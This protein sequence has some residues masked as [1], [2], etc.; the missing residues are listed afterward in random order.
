MTASDISQASYDNTHFITL[1]QLLLTLALL[2][3]SER[4]LQCLHEIIGKYEWFIVHFDS[5]FQSNLH[6]DWATIKNFSSIKVK[7][8]VD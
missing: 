4:W 7:I 1:S 5:W 8:T 6:Y 3:K 2:L